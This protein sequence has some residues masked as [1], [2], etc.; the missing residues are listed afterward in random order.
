M[1]RA[2]GETAQDN[3]CRQGRAHAARHLARQTMCLRDSKG[4]NNRQNIRSQDTVCG[5]PPP[6][7]PLSCPR[8]SLSLL[9]FS[10]PTGLKISLSPLQSVSK[11]FQH[12]CYQS[13]TLPSTIA[14]R[15]YIYSLFLSL[16]LEEKEK[17]LNLYKIH[18][19]LWGTGE[20]GLL[21]GVYAGVWGAPPWDS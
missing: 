21:H 6:C 9:L 15:G 12:I 3:K 11:H 2:A 19:R 1:Q 14:P 10:V 17:R 5:L 18:F 16:V 4:L 7:S 8:P 13:L 20:G